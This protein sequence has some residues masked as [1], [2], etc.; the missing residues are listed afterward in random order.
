[1]LEAR[2][3]DAPAPVE[4]A[5]PRDARYLLVFRVG[6]S[7]YALEGALVDHVSQIGRIVPVPT[8]PPHF[9]GVVHER[10]RVLAVVDLA[11]IFGAGGERARDGYRRLIVLEIRGR[12]L[13]VLAHEV[14]GLR[15]VAG[16][17]LRPASGGAGA[18]GTFA[19]PRGVVTLLDADELLDRLRSGPEARHAS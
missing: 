6:A 9:A 8:A 17:E 14:L 11:A 3:P 7:L 4:D 19:A 15:R 13:V 10:G 2:D 1:M 5:P 12:P 16:D 18:A